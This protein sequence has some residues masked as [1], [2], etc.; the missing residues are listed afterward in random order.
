KITPLIEAKPY[1]AFFVATGRG[2][3]K[4]ASI[5]LINHDAV[6]LAITGIE[7][8]SS[9]FSL[10][11]ETNQIGQ[12]YTLFLKLPGQGAPGRVAEAITLHTSNKKEP[13]LLIGAN[14][15]IHERVHIFP[16]DLDFGTMDG[17]QVKT[18]EALRKT[19]TQVLMVYRE[20]GTNF[21]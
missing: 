7:S 11:L 16:E 12:V 15:F 2:Q 9:R 4:E 19:L 14:T 18:N 5:Q 13:V 20:S 17:A 8:P 21:Q 6:P 3:P 1:P 10:R